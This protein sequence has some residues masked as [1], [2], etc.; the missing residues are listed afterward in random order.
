MTAMEE[1]LALPEEL[2]KQ[3][4]SRLDYYAIYDQED[5][6]DGTRKAILALGGQVDADGSVR[7]GER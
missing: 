6:A 4:L 3:V 2:R 1:W 5:R 7:R